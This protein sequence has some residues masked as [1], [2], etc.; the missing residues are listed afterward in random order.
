MT[1]YLFTTV[2]G[3]YSNPE[4]LPRVL[5]FSSIFARWLQTQGLLGWYDFS[6]APPLTLDTG[7]VAAIAPR[8]GSIAALS[9][10]TALRQPT[11]D[12]ATGRAAFSAANVTTLTAESGWP[13]S[14]VGLGVIAR[15]AATS[16]VTEGLIG[17]TTSASAS[18]LLFFQSN[19]KLRLR[20]TNGTNT[21]YGEPANGTP[22]NNAQFL[23]MADYDQDTDLARSR[24]GDGGGGADNVA[25]GNITMA[26]QWSL[27]ASNVAGG[28]PMTAE[29]ADV[30]LFDRRQIG[31]SV[32]TVLADYAR[33]M[34][35]AA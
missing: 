33:Q 22:P 11:Y 28:S 24:I 34:R 19:G 18:T 23:V 30:F 27:G 8:L 26:S 7:R 13:S 4:S 1:S 20:V 5:D 3:V 14:A 32:Q 21:T 12:A 15:R 9:Q 17:N 29:V 31:T 6:H 16:A 25:T 10:A 2:P 35:G